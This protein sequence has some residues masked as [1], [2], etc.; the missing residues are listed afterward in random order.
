[1]KYYIKPIIKSVSIKSAGFL[2]ESSHAQIGAGEANRPMPSKGYVGG[3]EDDDVTES[4][5]PWE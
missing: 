3:I 4:S 5:S 2:A 1:M